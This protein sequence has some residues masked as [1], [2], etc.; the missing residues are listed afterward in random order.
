MPAGAV[1]VPA[2]DK[3]G[4]RVAGGYEFLYNGWKHPSPNQTSCRM[5]AT[6][7]NIFPPYRDVQLDADLLKRL[8]LTKR[9]N[10]DM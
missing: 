4:K 5:G 9:E 10:V 1:P 3:T 2:D 8:G 6:R 7:D